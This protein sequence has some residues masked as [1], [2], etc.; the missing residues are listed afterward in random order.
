MLQVVREN[1][2]WNTIVLGT[3][4]EFADIRTW[5][6]AQ[7]NFFTQSDMESAAKVVVLGKTAAQNLF[8]TGEDIVGSEIRIRNVPLRVVGVLAQPK[9]SP[10]R[11]KTRTISSC[12]P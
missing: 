11:V 6:V 7:G 1:K 12:C 2:N 5:P 10:S 8:E 3:T 9:A 4:P